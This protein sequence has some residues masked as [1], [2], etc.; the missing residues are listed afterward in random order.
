[1]RDSFLQTH[2]GL[3]YVQA[4]GSNIE[5]ESY[6]LEEKG[7]VGFAERCIRPVDGCCRLMEDSPGWWS[8]NWLGKYFGPRVVGCY[9]S[10]WLD[11]SES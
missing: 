1:M 9:I 7:A 4:Y 3:L 11:L 10:T 5:G 8:S 2:N 6:G